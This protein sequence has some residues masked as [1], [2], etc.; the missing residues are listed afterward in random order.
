[1][2]IGNFVA[3]REGGRFEERLLRAGVDGVRRDCRGDQRIVFPVGE[4]VL[5][6]SQGLGGSF[7]VRGGEVDDRLAQ[8]AAHAGFFC[9]ARD[10]IL[11][12]IHVG[13]GGDAAAQHFQDAE[14]RAARHEVFVY[15]VGFGGEDVLLQPF[16]E[17]EIVGQA[18]EEAHGGV[19]VAVDQA[20]KNQGAFCVEP[21]CRCGIVR[22][23]VA[24]FAYGLDRIAGDGQGAVFD[25]GMGC[26][27]RDYCA[28]G[29]Q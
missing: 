24:A 29:Y 4:I 15:V 5:R 11:E 25:E 19:G 7:V 17:G 28:A 22:F 8:D 6:V 10:D 16:I 2:R 18:A 21:G 23:D 13:V 26:I 9:Y 20:G 27:H 14:P 3:P 1:M 12:V